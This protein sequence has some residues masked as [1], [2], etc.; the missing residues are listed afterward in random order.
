M[1]RL[2]RQNEDEIE[3]VITRLGDETIQTKQ[4]LER[5]KTEAIAREKAKAQE[6]VTAAKESEKRWSEK[7]ML[8][9]RTLQA[10]QDEAHKLKSRLEVLEAQIDMIVSA[11][12]CVAFFPLRL[13]FLMFPMLF[14]T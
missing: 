14:S 9:Q 10:S 3:A 8:T 2:T 12:T 1:D 11:H 5:E 4:T 13:P 6:D 7:F